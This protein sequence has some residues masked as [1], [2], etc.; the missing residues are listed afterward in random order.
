MAFV[1]VLGAKA[2]S[3]PDLV[4]PNTIFVTFAGKLFNTG[5]EVLNWLIAGMLIVA[6]MLSALNAIMGCARSLHQM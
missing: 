3:N 5:G 2:L 6:L 4:D 1:C